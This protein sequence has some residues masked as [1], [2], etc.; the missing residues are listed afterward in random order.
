MSILDGAFKNITRASDPV[1]QGVGG[2]A[3]LD[4]ILAFQVGHGSTTMKSNQNGLWLGAKKSTDAPF[5]VDMDGNVVASSIN[6]GGAYIPTGGAANDINVGGVK[7]IGTQIVSL[8]ITSTQISDDAISTPKLQANSVTANEIATNAI[9]AGK[10]SANAVES[11]KIAANAITSVK[12][13]AGSVTA[14]KINVTTLAAITA[15]LGT[16]TAGSINAALVTIT[17]LNANNITTGT[18]RAGGSGQPDAIV[19]VRDS[20]GTGTKLRWEGGSRMW[21][22]ASNRIGIN[23]LGSPMYIYVDSSE[24][25]IIPSSGQV[26]LR[27]GAYVDG[28]LNVNNGTLRVNNGNIVWY[29]SKLESGKDRYVFKDSSGNEKISLRPDGSN[30]SL[31]MNGY[32]LRLTSNKTAIV[33]T[34][35][36]YRALYCI[37]SPEV[38]FMDFF[39]EGTKPDPMFDE[40]TEGKSYFVPCYD[41]NG[42]KFL[43]VWR[44][45]AGHAH[46]RFDYKTL[47]EFE[48]NERFLQQARVQ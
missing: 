26:T 4:N 23:S 6:L 27:G 36:G 17:N 35:S 34:S 21:A 37:E 8:S 47:G 43:Q 29:D 46:H 25:V 3:Y 39:E 18:I 1:K 45:R 40:V 31:R 14:N 12:I 11:D 7:V 32:E 19:L 9:T 13:L 20:G 42:D 2:Q 22:D 41:G 48:Q 5:Y 38:W 28:H 24:R 16:I 15:N 10:I 44:R 30:S 33:P